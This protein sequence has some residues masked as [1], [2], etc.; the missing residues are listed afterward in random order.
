M[1]NSKS[2]MTPTE[3]R[4]KERPVMASYT[5]KYEVSVD[6]SVDTTKGRPIEGYADDMADMLMDNEDLWD[7]CPWMQGMAVSITDYKLNK[8]SST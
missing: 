2:A 5:I 4:V 6:I 1:F 3:S 7:G 8:N